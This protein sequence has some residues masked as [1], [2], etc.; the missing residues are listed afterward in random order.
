MNSDQVVVLAEIRDAIRDY[1]AEYR[2]VS[3]D[4]LK[5]QKTIV[6]QQ[7]KQILVNKLLMM[8]LFIVGVAMTSGIYISAH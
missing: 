2:R 3:D 5:G 8:I 1:T 6:A 4:I 7:K